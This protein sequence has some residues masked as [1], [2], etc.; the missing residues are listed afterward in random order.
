MYMY[1]HAHVCVC[2]W[3]RMKGCVQCVCHER[4]RDIR[5]KMCER[6]RERRLVSEGV[7]GISVHKVEEMMWGEQP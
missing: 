3:Q 4:E 5:V 1:E 7:G 2:T 6:V